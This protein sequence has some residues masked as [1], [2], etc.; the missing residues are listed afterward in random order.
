MTLRFGGGLT[1]TA[2]PA[3]A[4]GDDRSVLHQAL[5]VDRVATACNIACRCCGSHRPLAAPPVAFVTFA[6]LDG[7]LRALA[8]IR[9]Q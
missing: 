6:A 7:A 2:H 3:G 9:G 8:A 5:I 1:P 4:G